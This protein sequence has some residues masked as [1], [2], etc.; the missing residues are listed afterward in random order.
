MCFIRKAL[1]Y[2]FS[3]SELFWLDHILPDEHNRRRDDEKKA[4][5]DD[6]IDESK[7]YIISC[8][9]FDLFIF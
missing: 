6:P 3:Q 2:F 8:L 9:Y 1:D 4:M 5:E 7:V